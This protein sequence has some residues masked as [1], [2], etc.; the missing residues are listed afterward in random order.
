MWYAALKCEGHKFKSSFYTPWG[1]LPK[2]LDSQAGLHA[3]PVRGCGTRRL[4]YAAICNMLSPA[5]KRSK[6]KGKTRLK[7]KTA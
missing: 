6:S 5:Y 2:N 4:L 3:G 7:R 1:F